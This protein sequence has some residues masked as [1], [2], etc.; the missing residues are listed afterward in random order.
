MKIKWL[1]DYRFLGTAI[2]GL[3]FSASLVETGRVFPQ[4]LSPPLTLG[5]TAVQTSSSQAQTTAFTFKGRLRELDRWL[6]ERFPDLSGVLVDVGIGIDLRSTGTP[7]PIT[8]METAGRFRRHHVTVYGVDLLIPR[9]SV[10]IGGTVGLFNQKGQLARVFQ[11]GIEDGSLFG[12]DISGQLIELYEEYNAQR[13][14]DGEK[15]PAVKKISQEIEIIFEP[16]ELYQQQ[17]GAANVR[18]AEADVLSEDQ[19]DALIKK[20]GKASVIR[21]FN[22][23]MYFG[24]EERGKILKNLAKLAKE[25]ATLIEGFSFGREPHE[26]IFAEYVLAEEGKNWLPQ[27]LWFP[28]PLEGTDNVLDVDTMLL[29]TFLKN[30]PKEILRDLE[31]VYAALDDGNVDPADPAYLQSFLDFLQERKQYELIQ[32]DRTYIGIKVGAERSDKDEK[33]TSVIIQLENAL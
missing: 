11:N 18:F 1:H 29:P 14:L 27:V 10:R 20:M 17:T 28:I 4:A 32:N 8:T 16:F 12:K 33:T 31:E 26:T 21:V 24:I 2:A 23:L 9:A 5:Y 15:K 30:D 3:I 6:F 7:I 19:T 13:E 22:V 25:G